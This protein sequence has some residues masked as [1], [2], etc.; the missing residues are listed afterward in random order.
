LGKIKGWNRRA[1]RGDSEKYGGIAWI[2]KWEKEIEINEIEWKRK[3][4]NIIEIRW[5]RRKEIFI[6]FFRNR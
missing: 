6:K 1:Y 2:E 3:W 5:I 4:R